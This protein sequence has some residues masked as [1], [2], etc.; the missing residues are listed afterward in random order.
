MESRYFTFEEDQ[1]KIIVPPRGSNC[2]SC[3][4]GSCGVTL[5]NSEIF[6]ECNVRFLNTLDISEVLSVR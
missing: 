5:L 1:V 3:T 4:I 6:E 2:R